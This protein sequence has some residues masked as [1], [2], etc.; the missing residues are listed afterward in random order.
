M[1]FDI[2]S[3]GFRIVTFVSAIVAVLVGILF[4]FYALDERENTIDKE[5]QEARAIILMAESVREEMSRKWDLGLFSPEILREM[6]YTDQDD[7]MEKI[8]AAV[9]VVTAWETAQAKAEEAGYEFLTPREG[10]R[11]EDNEPD[12]LESQALRHFAENPEADE[13][14]II[15]HEQNA[16]RYFRPVR[17]GE[18]CLVCHGD[19][20]RSQELW[21]RD[22]G[23][24]ITGHKMD[25]KEVG[26]LHGAFEVVKSLD[27]A[28]AAMRANLWTGA[29]IALIMLGLAVVG[30]ALWIRKRVTRPLNTVAKGMSHAEQ[31]GDLNY[32]MQIDGRDELAVMG[33]GFNSFMQRIQTLVQQVTQS[34]KQ[35]GESA[36][37]VA[38]IGDKTRE[39]VQRQQAETEQVATAMNE[40]TATVEEVARNAASAA[41]ATNTADQEASAGNE[42]VQGTIQ[43]I[44]SL[45]DEVERASGVINRVSSDSENIGK[46]VEV[47]NE[48]AEQTNLLALNAA[49]E[50]ARAGEA[51]RG[52]AVVADE[53]RTLAQRTQKSTDEIRQMIETLQQGAGEAVQV[54]ETGREQATSTVETAGKAGESL[55][56][57][58][59]A[60]STITDMN[61]QIA[62]AA[63]EQ[64]ATADEINR[65]VTNITQVA[66]ETS[67]GAQELGSASEQLNQLAAELEE[68]L[69]Q[70]KS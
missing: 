53:V 30:L 69:A 32:R 7:R 50:A 45:A 24:D 66:D 56:N 59:D 5:V 38:R 15:D 9:P 28:D 20:E 19:P 40:M 64:S 43:S 31:E 18:V 63:E 49:I 33:Q 10:A 16:V 54:M 41:D 55:E 4:I 25:D 11:N 47:I 6:E 46:V 42:V 37:E 17:L 62:S 8:L 51:G 61:Q 44:R 14:H 12:E 65:N 68:R 26:D 36:S 34:A 2:H 57:I 35:V 48:I 3:L 27:E 22:D 67:V 1:K 58:N 23:Y 39:G 13:Y 52:F 60:V 21:G 29:G 70:F